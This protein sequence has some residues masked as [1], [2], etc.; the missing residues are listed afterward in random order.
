[1]GRCKTIGNQG[2]CQEETIQVSSSG[3]RQKHKAAHVRRPLP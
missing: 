3:R 1:M 2:T